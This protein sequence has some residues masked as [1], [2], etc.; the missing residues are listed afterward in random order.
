MGV[1]IGGTGNR[2]TRARVQ[3]GNVS[4]METRGEHGNKGEQGKEQRCFY[5][6]K[7]VAKPFLEN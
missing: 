6:E 5:T 3:E 4:V 1:S 2:G 7:L